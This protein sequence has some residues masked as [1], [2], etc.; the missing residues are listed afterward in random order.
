MGHVKR[1]EVCRGC[2]D[3]LISYGIPDTLK[4]HKSTLHWRWNLP[5]HVCE[6]IL[7]GQVS[8]KQALPRLLHDIGICGQGNHSPS[9]KLR[10]LR[11]VEV[12]VVA[13]FENTLGAYQARIEVDDTDG[14]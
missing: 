6:V 2:I 13:I 5:V 1:E 7:G 14:R 8:D 11:V 3:S 10:R 12:N 4:A 9:R